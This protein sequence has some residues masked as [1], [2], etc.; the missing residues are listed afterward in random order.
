[1]QG[2][3]ILLLHPQYY[4]P[5][6]YVQYLHGG[7][8]KKTRPSLT[9]I[10]YKNARKMALAPIYGWGG[11]D[12]VQNRAF[13]LPSHRW[14]VIGFG[15]WSAL[16]TFR[17]T[18]TLPLFSSVLYGEFSMLLTFPRL[19]SLHYSSKNKT[20]YIILCRVINEFK[21]TYASKPS[22][23]FS[24]ASSKGDTIIYSWYQHASLHT[25]ADHPIQWLINHPSC[26][27]RFRYNG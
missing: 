14:I 17:L 13:L 5:D 26:C 22:L 1:M 4:Y 15:M 18:C 20:L 25:P 9:C 11:V 7:P 23:T 3:F 12:S 16:P 10:V 6:P 2:P 24:W 19:T 21:T 27:I 8:C